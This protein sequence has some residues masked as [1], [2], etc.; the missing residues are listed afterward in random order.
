ML[1]GVLQV[2]HLLLNSLNVQFQLLLEPDVSSDLTLEF[3]E[4][5]FVGAGR[6]FAFSSRRDPLTQRLKLISTAFSSAAAIGE[7]L[8]QVLVRLVHVEGGTMALIGRVEYHAGVVR[9]ETAS[10]LRLESGGW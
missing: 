9:S 6:V 4:H 8:I 3:L 2:L 7:H 5:V 10:L 1:V